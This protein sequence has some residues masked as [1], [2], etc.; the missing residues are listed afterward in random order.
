MS[1]PWILNVVA[2]VLA[3]IAAGGLL[4]AAVSRGAARRGFSFRVFTLGLTLCGTALVVGGAMGVFS[5]HLVFDGLLMA[6]LGAGA[7]MRPPKGVR[8]QASDGQAR[9]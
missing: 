5:T 4:L 9:D 6:L 7:K 2:G 1:L 3:L 8:T